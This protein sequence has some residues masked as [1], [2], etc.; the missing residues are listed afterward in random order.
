MR[1]PKTAQA[2]ARSFWHFLWWEGGSDANSPGI[3]FARKGM[4]IARKGKLEERPHNSYSCEFA[5]NGIMQEIKN[6]QLQKKQNLK[7]NEFAETEVASNGLCK[8]C[9]SRH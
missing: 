2:A 5:R 4:E 8:E 3:E 7:G 6:W 1:L 9:A